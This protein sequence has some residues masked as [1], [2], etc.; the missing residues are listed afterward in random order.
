MKV[1]IIGVTETT[2]WLNRFLYSIGIIRIRVE[3]HLIIRTMRS[4][5]YAIE[6]FQNLNKDVL[7]INDYQLKPGETA[8]L[9]E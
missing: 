7:F 6:Y 2:S 9:I 5:S 1:Y 3:E 4:T 8:Q